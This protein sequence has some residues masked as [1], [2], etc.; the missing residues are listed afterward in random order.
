MF[1]TMTE[2]IYKCC[3]CSWHGAADELAHSISYR[4]EYQGRSAFEREPICPHCKGELEDI[5]Y[6]EF[7]EGYYAESAC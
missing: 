5:D 7:E 4:G 2:P 3:R 6:S 1:T